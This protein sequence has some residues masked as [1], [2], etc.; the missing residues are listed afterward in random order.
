LSEELLKAWAK[1]GSDCGSGAWLTDM[2][3][4]IE[5]PSI[6]VVGEDGTE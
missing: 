3:V 1:E 6:D 5:R 2:V 4:G